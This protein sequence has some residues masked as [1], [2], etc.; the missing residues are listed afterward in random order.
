MTNWHVRS[1][2]WSEFKK[3]L[4]MVAVVAGCKMLRSGY[5]RSF[6]RSDSCCSLDPLPP[7]NSVLF[8]S[9]ERRLDGIGGR[10]GHVSYVSDVSVSHLQ[11]MTLISFW[12]SDILV[13]YCDAILNRSLWTGYDLCSHSHI[14]PYPILSH[15]HPYPILYSVLQSP[16]AILCSETTGH[17]PKEVFLR[18]SWQLV[19]SHFS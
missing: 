18:V 15:I 3:C 2:T 1:A 12:Y 19:T 13:T 16:V 9:L 10:S 17:V 7:E 4:F 14:H 11:R 6:A 8:D 5:F